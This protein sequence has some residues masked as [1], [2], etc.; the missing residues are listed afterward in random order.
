MTRK[1]HRIKSSESVSSLESSLERYAGLLPAE[2]FAILLEEL[3]QPLV[4]AIRLNSLKTSKED[5]EDCI[6]RYGWEL[7]AVPFCNQGYRVLHAETPP[8]QTIEHRLGDFYIQDAASMLPA[9]LFD[10]SSS[11]EPLILDLAASPGG[12]TTHLVDRVMDRGVV[13]ANDS[14]QERLTALRIVL[15][16]WST[17]SCAITCF[18]GERFG[19]WF[20]E[21][22]DAVLLDAPC[23]MDGLRATEA[24]PLRPITIKERAGLARR[25]VNL[26]R[27][28]IQAAKSG[29]QVVYS[30]C[31]LAPEEN[32]GVLDSLLKEHPGTFEIQEI[33]SRL[34]RPAPGLEQDENSRF[35]AQVK[36]AARLWPHIFHTAGFFAAK[37]I[38]LGELPV[39]KL[40]PP[41]RSISHTGFTPLETQSRKKVNAWIRDDYGFELNTWLEKQKLAL[42]QHGSKVLA[43]PGFFIRD[44]SELPVRYLGLVIGEISGSGFEPSH[45]FASRFGRSFI[46][47]YITLQEEMLPTW[48]QGVDI[49]PF[50]TKE[51]LIGKIIVIRDA[52]GRHLGC[53]RVQKDRI[54]NLLPR[55]L[56]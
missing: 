43:L 21:T 48:L 56:L 23:S 31:T 12:K 41:A 42:W 28:A 47:G 38:K 34:S 44:F 7:E 29:G 4:S 53:G 39:K 49:H 20:P 14:S 33:H 35:D 8:S 5:L 45:D 46:N 1:K 19:S 36:Y 22:F 30:T 15:Q 51:S 3:K 54:K 24:H 11:Q 6:N 50:Q 52:R 10:I 37:I 25:Q 32:E 17:A 40:D 27:S 13:I 9:E 18:P 2:D 26:L 16:T 55:R